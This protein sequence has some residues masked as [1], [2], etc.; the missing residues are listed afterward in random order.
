MAFKEITLI[1]VPAVTK[2]SEEPSVPRV[3]IACKA[4]PKKD[5]VFVLIF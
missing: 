3:Y 2:F 4:L 5:E 1:T